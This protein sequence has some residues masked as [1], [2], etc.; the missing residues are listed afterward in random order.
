METAVL[1]ALVIVT[2]LEPDPSHQTETLSHE[3]ILVV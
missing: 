1:R 2:D 3:L